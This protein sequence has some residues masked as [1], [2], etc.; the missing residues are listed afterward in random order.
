M[1]VLFSY[2]LAI[3]GTIIL[4][5][6]SDRVTL[7]LLAYMINKYMWP[8]PDVAGKFLIWCVY[9]LHHLFTAAKKLLVASFIGFCV[10]PSLVSSPS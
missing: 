2:D 9:I 8:L 1:F 4:L 6:G 10:S 5:I 3:S 7:E